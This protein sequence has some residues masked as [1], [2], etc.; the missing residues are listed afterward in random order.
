LEGEKPRNVLNKVEA[1]LAERKRIFSDTETFR[2]G[3][4]K[5]SF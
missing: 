4:G 3:E 1:F 2:E 5:F